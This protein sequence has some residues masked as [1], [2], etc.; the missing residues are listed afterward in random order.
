MDLSIIIPCYNLESYIKTCLDSI[1]MQNLPF[2]RYEVIIVNDGSTDNTLGVINNFI[3]DNSLKNF[4]VFSKKNE[5]QSIA[6]NFALDVAKGK[7]IWFIDGDDYILPDTL[8]VLLN[9]MSNLNLDILWF[10]HNL[11]DE[12]HEILLKPEVDI[13]INISEDVNSGVFYLQNGF[14]QSCM[15][16]MFLFAR[17]FINNYK[18]RFVP[19][20]FLED[21][22]F[23]SQAIDKAQR[24]SYLNLDV[25]RYVIRTLGST[26]RDPNNYRKRLMDAF[27]VAHNLKVYSGLANY[28]DY[29]NE[30]TSS[31]AVYK[32][33]EIAKNCDS[34]LQEEI[35]AFLKKL[36]LLPLPIAGNFKLRCMAKA[37]NFNLI[38]T[39][40]VFKYI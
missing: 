19:G 20:I 36:D 16:V 28:P 8:A 7:Y 30:F 21:I 22:I 38:L 26:M 6:R 24:M 27:Y 17:E 31:I 23:T 11:V 18:L 3:S 9:K 12:C 29:F 2:E 25:Y 14:K 33:R 34:G 35:L 37:L 40:K 13:K 10:D 15:P 39:L 5:K 1:L 32:L 4:S